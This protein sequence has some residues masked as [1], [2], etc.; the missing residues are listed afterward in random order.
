MRSTNQVYLDT[1]ADVYY[2]GHETA[3]RGMKVLELLG[4]RLELDPKDNIITLPYVATN[5][6]YAKEE[7]RWYYAATTRI[8]F[9]EKIKKVWQKF[10]DDGI[11][12]NSNYGARIFAEQNGISQWDWVKAKLQSDKDSRQ[13]VLNINNINDK[14]QETKDFPCTVYCQ[15]FIRDD[16]LYWITNM[17]SNDIFYGLRNDLY[18]FTEMQKRMANEL[19]VGTS[20]YIHFAGSLHLYEK[21]MDKVKKLLGVKND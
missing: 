5:V 14:I 19:G 8:D 1:L 9:S 3:P 7:L 17:R 15:T 10:S 21:D 18:C 2:K 6:E 11:N 16:K 20:S 12:V 13:A 4:Y